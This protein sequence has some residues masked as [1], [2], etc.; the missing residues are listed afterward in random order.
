[1]KKAKRK[2]TKI[3]DTQPASA[4]PVKGVEL[5]PDQLFVHFGRLSDSLHHKGFI[6]PGYVCVIV[7]TDGKCFTYGGNLSLPGDRAR[8]LI[9]AASKE[10]ASA[11]AEQKEMQTLS[12]PPAPMRADFSELR[13]A[14]TPLPRK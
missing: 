10:L 3:R 5:T 4:E 6:V 14:I 11:F 8:C 2:P 12:G 1:M 7:Q 13:P 9:A